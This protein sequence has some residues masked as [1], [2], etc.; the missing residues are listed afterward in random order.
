MRSPGLRS[1]RLGVLA[2]VMLSLPV[3]ST[4]AAAEPVVLST[5][6]IN[7]GV[8][9][10]SEFGDGTGRFV[11][12]MTPV[13]TIR[14]FSEHVISDAAVGTTFVANA[15][16]DAEFAEIARQMTNGVGNYIEWTFGATAGTGGGTGAPS[17][18]N[19]FGLAPDVQD[20]AGHII[21]SIAL[22]VDAFSSRASTEFPNFT[23]LSFT[24]R[25][26]VIGESTGV[27][28][29]PVPE[30]ATLLLVGF[31]LAG[32]ARARGRA[33]GPSART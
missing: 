33:K 25:V 1:C 11:F 29:A 4:R 20:F 2:A 24:G 18:R 15:G 26:D 12:A 32:A 8:G 27:T 3:L 9:F 6:F 23:Q 17:E 16:N 21:H 30:P 31:G 5:L 28:P 10:P 13:S 14:L 7:T 19:L 22:H